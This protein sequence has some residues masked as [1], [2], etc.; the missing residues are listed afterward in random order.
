MEPRK[1]SRIGPPL[2]PSLV[3]E[4][5]RS[6]SRQAEAGRSVIGPPLPPA[7]LPAGP[8]KD[9]WAAVRRREAEDACETGPARHPGDVGRE[10]WMTLVPE[11]TGFRGGGEVVDGKRGFGTG[12][13]VASGGGSAVEARKAP[14]RPGDAL[15]EDGDESDSGEEEEERVV[16]K[17]RVEGGASLLDMHRGTR[18]REKETEGPGK[19]KQFDREKEFSNHKRRDVGHY[20]EKGGGLAGKYGNAS[21]R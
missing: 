2:P 21:G 11:V 8:E 7:A 9:A 6:A 17:A 20:A 5:E 12:R 14:V 3:R 15:L 1:R 19:L 13:S 18:E 10:D 16:K 4:A